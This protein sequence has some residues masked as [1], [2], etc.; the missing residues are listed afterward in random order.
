MQTE[1]LVSPADARTVRDVLEVLETS[2]QLKITRKA[3][4]KSVKRAEAEVFKMKD[5]TL[6]FGIAATHLIPMRGRK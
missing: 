4:E 2:F 1:D 3:S 5:I 6:L